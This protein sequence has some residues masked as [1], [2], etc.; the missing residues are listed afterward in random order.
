MMT[1]AL[2]MLAYGVTSD[3]MDEYLRIG[4][5]TAMKSVAAPGIFSK[6]FIKKK[7]EYIDIPK[8]I[9]K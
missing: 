3:L 7:I 6:G 1:T 4:E 8:K 2:R 9:N 5:K